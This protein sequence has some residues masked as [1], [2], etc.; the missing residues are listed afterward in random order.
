MLTRLYGDLRRTYM[1]PKQRI[2]PPGEATSHLATFVARH[3]DGRTWVEAWKAWKGEGGCQYK[4]ERSFTRD[5]RKAYRQVTGEDLEW[6][7]PAA[8]RKGKK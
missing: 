8:H 4:D 5:A 1:E 3:N 7:G 2:R 6:R